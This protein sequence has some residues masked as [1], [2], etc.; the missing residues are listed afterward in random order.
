MPAAVLRWPRA[1]AAD[2]QEG[3]RKTGVRTRHKL[4]FSAKMFVQFQSLTVRVLS[5][6][7]CWFGA[8]QRYL[9]SVRRW[10]QRS[11]GRSAAGCRTFTAAA[12][13]SPSSSSLTLWGGSLD[14]SNVNSKLCSGTLTPVGCAWPHKPE[15]SACQGLECE[16]CFLFQGHTFLSHDFIFVQP[17]FTLA[18]TRR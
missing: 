10:L 8:Q 17:F 9:F 3:T 6:N 18:I 7:T 12:S 4:G 11:R 15:F 5:P 14:P 2:R 13:P 16:R 1:T